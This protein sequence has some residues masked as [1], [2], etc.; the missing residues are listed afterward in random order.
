M[1]HFAKVVNGTVTEIIV[2]DEDFIRTLPLT[3][4]YWV[5]TSYN[6][7]GGKHLDPNTREEDDGTPMRKNFAGIGYTYDK[8][9]D[10][11]IPPQPYDSWTIDEDT[12]LWVAPTAMP[13][14]GNDYIW[15]EEN[16]QWIQVSESE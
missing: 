11:F 16:G 13:D 15:D 14:D 1:S 12:C 10:A 6:T 5:Q 7:H 9:R 2:A 4:G 3:D 8:D